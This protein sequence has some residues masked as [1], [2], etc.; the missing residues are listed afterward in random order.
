MRPNWRIRFTSRYPISQTGDDESGGV[1]VPLMENISTPDYF[2][3]VPCHNKHIPRPDLS[4]KA[5][6][7]WN[8]PNFVYTDSDQFLFTR[9]PFA[10][11]FPSIV[12]ESGCLV[13]VRVLVST[14]FLRTRTVP[15]HGFNPGH[16]QIYMVKGWH[17]LARQLAHLCP[18][19]MMHPSCVGTCFIHVKVS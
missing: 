13:E 19:G 9:I 3:I 6:I 10:K 1:T 15:W 16:A 8:I 18:G 5:T 7:M 14:N 11:W 4:S 12:T 17:V 2:L